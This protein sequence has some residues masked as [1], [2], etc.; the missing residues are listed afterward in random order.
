MD[1][2]KKL[3]RQIYKEAQVFSKNE[4]LLAS[5]IQETI[6]V[7]S[8]LKDALS[9]HLASKMHSATLRAM[10]FR[11]VIKEAFGADKK[12][13]DKIACD[14]RAI[15]NRDPAS[16]TYLAPLLY[17][18]GFHAL[19]VYRVAHWLWGQG[20]KSLAYFLQNRVSEVFQADIHPAA[21]IGCGVFFDHGTSLVI[22][23]TAVIEN[24]VSILH[25]V[26]LG[27]TG[28]DSG[29]RHPKVRKG[30][31]I[32]SGAKLLGNIEIGEGAKIGAGSVVLK[33]VPKHS[34]VAGVPAVVV[35]KPQCESP[36]LEM[37]HFL[38]YLA[39]VPDSLDF[40][41]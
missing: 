31:L 8:S 32:G 2:N 40:Q 5:F 11:D 14:L 34:T 33:D 16:D 12:M 1:D 28:K 36:A 6:L 25:E 3:W 35:G 23:E 22:G 7:H 37:D 21:K 30:V 26:T 38:S 10:L 19:Q 24:D 9:F 39:N 4:P 41:I 29:D 18:K 17:F 27:G 20:R 15:F 13:E